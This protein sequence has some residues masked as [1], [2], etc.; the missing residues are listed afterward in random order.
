MNKFNIKQQKADTIQFAGSGSIV[1]NNAGAVT[2]NYYTQEKD[3]VKIAANALR[4]RNYSTAV[5]H[6]MAALE[7][8]SNNPDLYYRLALALLNG[9]RPHRHTEES[10]IE[11]KR[12]LEEAQALP[13]ARALLVLVVEDY[14]L[15]WQKYS[16]VSPELMELIDLISPER[17]AEI[18]FHVP[19]REARTWQALAAKN[20]GKWD[21]HGR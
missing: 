6:Y 11:T 16:D 12:Y 18:V 3:H 10:I 13:E 14:G 7:T 17:A 9:V 8:E 5:A 15:F 20:S 19:A 21:G 2:H 1:N 4:V